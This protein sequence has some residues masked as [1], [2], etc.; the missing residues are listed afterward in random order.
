MNDVFTVVSWHCK[1][2]MGG[3]TVVGWICGQATTVVR[4]G[5]VTAVELV[6]VV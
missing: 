3:V 6:S 4:C 1:L 5:L 2:A